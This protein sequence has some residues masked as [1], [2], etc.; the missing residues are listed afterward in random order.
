MIRLMTIPR[1]GVPLRYPALHEVTISCIG[2]PASASA[3]VAALIHA[4][5]VPADNKS[6][7]NKNLFLMFH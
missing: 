1:R 4:D 2:I 3:N 6:Q 5:R 7:F